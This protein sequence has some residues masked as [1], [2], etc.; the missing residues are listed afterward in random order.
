MQHVTSQR[1]TAAL[2]DRRHDLELPQAQM[3]VLSVSPGSTMG[4]EDIRDLQCG[5]HDGRNLYGRQGLQRAD[6]LAQKIGGHLR[7]QRRGV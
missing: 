3:G 4:A 5:T 2:L 1:R 7:V 6:H